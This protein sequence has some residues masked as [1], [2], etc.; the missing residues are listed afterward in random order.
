MGLVLEV[1]VGDSVLGGSGAL[2]CFKSGGFGLF[3]SSGGGM[4]SYRVELWWWSGGCCCRVG[5]VVV[6]G[7]NAVV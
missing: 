6:V 4:V 3:Q 7:G 2:I 5:V 1:A